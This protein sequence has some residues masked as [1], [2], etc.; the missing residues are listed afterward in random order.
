MFPDKGH[1]HP[2]QEAS[3]DQPDYNGKDLPK[4]Y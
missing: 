1:Y 3:G 2:G 4:Q